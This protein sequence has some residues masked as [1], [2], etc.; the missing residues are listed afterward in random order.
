MLMFKKLRYWVIGGY[1]IPIFLMIVSATIVSVNV[2]RVQTEVEKLNRSRQIA[3][4][5]ANLSWNLQAMSR[6]LRG[7][8]LD[9]NP[10][11]RSSWNQ[12]KDDANQIIDSL[13]QTMTDEQQLKTINEI[14]QQY[15]DLAEFHSGLIQTVANNQQEQARQTWIANGTGVQIAEDTSG[16]I[17][18]M[19][20]REEELVRLGVASQTQA[21]N[22]LLASVWI[23]I[24][25][26]TITSIILG[27]W[28]ITTIVQKITQEANNIAL[29]AT[30]IATTIEEQERVAVQQ[31]ASVNETTTSMDELGASSRQCAEQASAASSGARQVLALAGSNRQEDTYDGSPSLREKMSQVQAQILRLSENLSQIY[32][33]TNLVSDL[34]NQTNMLALNAS[35]EAVRAGEHGK[36]FGVVASEI[37]KLADQS[38]KSAE[39]IGSLITE[40]QNSTN[41][42]VIV[43][44]EGT[45]AVEKIIAS[46]NDV[47]VN[48]QQISLNT[49]Q[50]A[51][52][53]EQV[54][55]AMN[56][57]NTA[58]QET[59][60]GLAQSRSGT[61]QLNNTAIGLKN[62]V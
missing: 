21:L 59:A 13:T 42:T 29:A 30:E 6:T 26:A 12:A 11:S 5:V 18:Q 61:E 37:R 28:I 2:G 47:A 25:V 35:V 31:A 40:I 49:K 19:N 24:G 58:A 57:L 32:N 15:N 1:T 4:G 14:R 45:K 46:I 50:Q 41:S 22:N 55:D 27:S 10:T 16:L 9:N 39:K 33:I 52:A 56:S 20:N 54:I 8:L 7:Y 44:E 17:T 23:S 34:A 3:Q 62:L 36:G 51:M 38:R 48:I 43:T 60:N 53:V